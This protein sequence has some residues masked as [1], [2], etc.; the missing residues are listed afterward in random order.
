MAKKRGRARG[1]LEWG[2]KLLPKRKGVMELNLKCTPANADQLNL[3]DLRE[4]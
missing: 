1:V 3:H 4:D 2:P